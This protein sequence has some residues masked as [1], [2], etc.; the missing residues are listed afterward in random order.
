MSASSHRQAA[1]AFLIDPRGRFLL[2]RRDSVPN[3]LYP[4]K[5][6]LFGGHREAGE[7][8]LECIVREVHE[9]TSYLAS[10]ER[11]EHLWSYVG[12][13]YAVNG[14]TLRGEY[15]ILRDVPVE[16]LN[17][18]EGF[19]LIAERGDLLSLAE[20]CTP[21]VTMSLQKFFQRGR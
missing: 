2:Q 15:Y 7:T 4:G 20:D 14:G 16:A 11:F 12:S 9:E 21:S 18:T 5:I 1:G 19:L 3:I 13:D 17:V 6:G 10:P 8:F